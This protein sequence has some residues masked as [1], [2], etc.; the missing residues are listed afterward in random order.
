MRLNSILPIFSCYLYFLVNYQTIGD[1]GGENAD[2][3][4][5]ML[6]HEARGP[7]RGSFIAGKSVHNQRIGMYN[8]KG[9]QVFKDLPCNDNGLILSTGCLAFFHLGSTVYLKIG[10]LFQ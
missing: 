7:D 1:Y 9:S 8:L 5:F 2:V 6:T 4:W 3:A 10:S